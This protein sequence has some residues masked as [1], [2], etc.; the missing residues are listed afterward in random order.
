M[1][2]DVWIVIP[3]V[4]MLFVVLPAVILHYITQWRKTKALSSDD[5][6]MLEDLWHSA[7]AME[8]RIETLEALLDVADRSEPRRPSSRRTDVNEERMPR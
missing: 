1:P 5:E 4:G 8:R 7:R 2:D 3:V 6:H